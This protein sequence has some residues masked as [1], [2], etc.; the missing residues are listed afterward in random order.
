MTP[1]ELRA[2]VERLRRNCTGTNEADQATMAEAADRIEELEAGLRLAAI[3]F[4][5]YA[6]L[7]RAKGTAEGNDKGQRN[8]DRADQLRALI[9]EGK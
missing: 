5:E 4:D 8:Q 1:A 3:W 9:G 6:L 2:L 7:H